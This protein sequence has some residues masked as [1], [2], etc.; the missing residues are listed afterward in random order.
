[1]N[2]SW[3]KDCKPFDFVNVDISFCISE[4][5]YYGPNDVISMTEQKQ[6]TPLSLDRAKIFDGCGKR[7]KIPVR[8][9]RANIPARNLRAKLVNGSLK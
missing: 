5:F 3:L 8:F 4:D 7:V 6:T 2:T 1:M 9:M